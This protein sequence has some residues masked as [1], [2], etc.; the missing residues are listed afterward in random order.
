MP[1][2][3]VSVDSSEPKSNNDLIERLSK[4]SKGEIEN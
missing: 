2:T 3:E 4:K 1:I